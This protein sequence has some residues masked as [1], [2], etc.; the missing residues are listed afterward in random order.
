[1]KICFK[2]HIKKQLTDFYKH[3]GMADGY[4]NKCKGCNKKDTKKRQDYLRKNDNEWVKQERI[5]G[6]EKFNRLGYAEKYKPSKEDKAKTMKGYKERYPEK[7]RAQ[8][9]SQHVHPVNPKNQMHHWSYN[10]IHFKD[11]I[12]LSAK[13]HMKLHRYMTYDQERRMYRDLDGVLLDT[14]E[15][16]LKYYKSLSDKE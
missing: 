1:M 6:R 5:R 16:H 8:Q 13:E 14:K 12:E 9:L 2:C 7:I 4:L 15:K 10:E 3:K 11:C